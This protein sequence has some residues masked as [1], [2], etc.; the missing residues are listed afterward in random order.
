MSRSRLRV[1]ESLRALAR[2]ARA[3]G[4][5]IALRGSGHLEW[6]SPDGAVIITPSTP[7]DRRSSK[8]T[9]A[10]LLRAGLKEEP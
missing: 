2:A 7:G 3:K 4:W 6:R 1:P 9:R 5:T 10:R 8:N